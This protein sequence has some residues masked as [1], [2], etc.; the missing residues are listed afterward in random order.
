MNSER[1]RAVTRTGGRM[2]SHFE[3]NTSSVIDMVDSGCYEDEQEMLVQ[4][5]GAIVS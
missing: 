5:E 4:D 2:V 1:K 3:G